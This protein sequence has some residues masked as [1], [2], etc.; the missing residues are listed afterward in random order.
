[1]KRATDLYLDFLFS[2]F[3]LIWFRPIGLNSLDS[4][5]SFLLPF[6]FF[7]ERSF[8]K[9]LFSPFPLTIYAR[10]GSIFLFATPT[11]RKHCARSA[12]FFFDLVGQFAPP[13]AK[14]EPVFPRTYSS[15]PG[16]GPS[17]VPSG[18]LFASA[19][20]AFKILPHPY[21]ACVCFQFF[22]SPRCFAEHFIRVQSVGFSTF[23]P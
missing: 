2:K 12:E 8:S 16:Y 15:E 17:R 20:C 11:S 4:F 10:R 23:P 18:P 19:T 3:P 7:F 21:C 1:L 6:F 9:Q 5:P 22:P 14:H 13:P